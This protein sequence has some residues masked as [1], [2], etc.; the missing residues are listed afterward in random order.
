[1]L[2]MSKERGA[3]DLIVD[4]FDYDR[5]GSND[6]LGRAFLPM[7]QIVTESQIHW[8]QVRCAY[9]YFVMS[10]KSSVARNVPRKV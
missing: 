8:V 1:M 7:S 6:F 9:W 5:F 3:K 2:I 10:I 4:I